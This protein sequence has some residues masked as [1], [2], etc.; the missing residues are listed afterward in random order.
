[1][2]AVWF[3][4]GA[5][6]GPEDGEEVSELGEKAADGFGA[7]GGGAGGW[8]GVQ[9]AGGGEGR[10]EEGEG[11]QDGE[12]TL[13]HEEPPEAAR[14]RPVWPEGGPQKEVCG[15]GLS[16]IPQKLF[17]VALSIGPVFVRRRVR[18]GL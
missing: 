13:G 8:L 18:S 4:T 11:E 9:G 2:G 12:E 6:L 10:K 17:S 15:A 7:L 14:G 5:V 3:E 16:P 1:V